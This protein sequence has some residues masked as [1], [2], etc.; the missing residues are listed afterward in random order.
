[1]ENKWYI[2]MKSRPSLWL[3]STIYEAYEVYESS[4]NAAWKA[5]TLCLGTVPVVG[6]SNGSVYW[7]ITLVEY[8]TFLYTKFP[9]RTELSY[10]T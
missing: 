2:Y 8:V 7:Y 3:I 6:Y 10:V 5:A 1:M 9:V 4:A